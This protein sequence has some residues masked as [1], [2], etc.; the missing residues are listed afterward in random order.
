[1]KLAVFA[2]GTAVAQ[3]PPADPSADMDLPKIDKPLYDNYEALLN[4]AKD[5]LMYDYKE[6]SL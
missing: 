1:M 5:M 2:V 6:Q 4:N 3:I